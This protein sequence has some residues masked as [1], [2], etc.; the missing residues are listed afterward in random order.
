MLGFWYSVQS[1]SVTK[2]ATD[3]ENN[4]V[5]P[6]AVP[7]LLIRGAGISLINFEI[8]TVHPYVKKGRSRA[9]FQGRFDSSP[10]RSTPY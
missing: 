5:K 7:E 3:R 2:E 9:T 6:R 8:H 10:A 4:K 1:Q